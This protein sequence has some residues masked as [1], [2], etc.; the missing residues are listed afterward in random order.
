MWSGR[1]AS[2]IPWVP[3][4]NIGPWTSTIKGIAWNYAFQIVSGH[5]KLVESHCLRV[6]SLT[7][8]SSG[9]HEVSASW[10]HSLPLSCLASALLIP[11]A[12]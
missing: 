3:V 6:A 2:P 12:L 7:A 1:L 11:W 9:M 4:K 5:T 8:L 10:L